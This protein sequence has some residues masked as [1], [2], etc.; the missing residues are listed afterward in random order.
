MRTVTKLSPTVT[1]LR[2]I[3]QKLGVVIAVSLM[4]MRLDFIFQRNGAVKSTAFTSANGHICKAGIK[5]FSQRVSELSGGLEITVIVIGTPCFIDVIHFP[6]S[7][8]VGDLS[9]L[10]FHHALMV[11]SDNGIVLVSVHHSYTNSLTTIPHETGVFQRYA[12]I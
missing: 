3:G 7:A 1:S 8:L 2:L 4:V 5:M 9:V 11:E 6:G 10:T 12:T